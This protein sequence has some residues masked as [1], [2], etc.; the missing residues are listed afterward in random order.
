MSQNRCADWHNHLSW[1]KLKKQGS[2]QSRWTELLWQLF[3]PCSISVVLILILYIHRMVIFHVYF[4][5]LAFN[6]LK[7]TA[8][9]RLAVSGWPD[10]CFFISKAVTAYW[11]HRDMVC[12][13]LL[14]PCV[15]LCSNIQ[16]GGN[17]CPGGLQSCLSHFTVLGASC[18]WIFSWTVLF[19]GIRSLKQQKRMTLSPNNQALVLSCFLIS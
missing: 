1:G 8:G 18:L 12:G 4:K 13:S 19:Q 9:N 7:C 11:F 10:E 17:P 14:R 15:T 16:H 5:I 2:Y 3:A 6:P